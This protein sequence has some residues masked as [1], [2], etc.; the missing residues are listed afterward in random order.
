VVKVLQVRVTMAGMV[1][2]ETILLQEAVAVVVAQVLLETMHIVGLAVM[3]VMDSLLHLLV[4][5]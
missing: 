2:T 5:H 1:C 3:Q 4:Q